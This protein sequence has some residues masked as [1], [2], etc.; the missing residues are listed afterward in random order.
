MATIEIWVDGNECHPT[1]DLWD[2]YFE[3]CNCRWE[4]AGVRTDKCP[5]PGT[6]ELRRVELTTREV[7][8]LLAK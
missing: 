1:C 8:D 7:C 2:E 6:Y 5:G 4:V 3:C